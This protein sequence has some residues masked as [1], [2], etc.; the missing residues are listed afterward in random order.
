MSMGDDFFCWILGPGKLYCAGSCTGAAQAQLVFCV[1]L[2]RNLH[3]FKE[4]R[5]FWFL[6][7]QTGV[8]LA[9]RLAGF[10]AAMKFKLTACSY[11]QLHSCECDSPT[12]FWG[13]GCTKTLSR[14][15]GFRASSQFYWCNKLVAE[16]TA[17][18]ESSDS[19]KIYAT[20]KARMFC[21]MNLDSSKLQSY[22]VTHI[23]MIHHLRALSLQ[24]R[25]PLLWLAPN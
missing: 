2:S 24:F 11:F 5:H 19:M 13:E 7:K 8:V 18:C 10:L 22:L 15:V 17:V 14:I 20:P 6:R 1:P 4:I 21:L 16:E 9:G 12:V 3:F 25:V 23:N